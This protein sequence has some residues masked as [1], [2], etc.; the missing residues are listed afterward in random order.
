MVS[1][2]FEPFLNVSNS[3]FSARGPSCRLILMY[4]HL[5]LLRLPPIVLA[6]IYSRD[7]A[8]G[9]LSSLSLETKL[10]FLKSLQKFKEKFFDKKISYD[11]GLSVPPNFLVN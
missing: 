5:I 10:A 6:N 7:D 9:I 2:S 11:R 3:A 8:V 1:S 4:P